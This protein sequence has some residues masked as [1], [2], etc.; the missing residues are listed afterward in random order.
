MFDRAPNTI[1]ELVCFIVVKFFAAMHKGVSLVVS[2]GDQV[3][4]DICG[5]NE[6]IQ[7]YLLFVDFIGLMPV[8]LLNQTL[9]SFIV[10]G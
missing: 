1:E 3:L 10:T 4:N 7:R 9:K 8:S 5:H 2:S 6:T